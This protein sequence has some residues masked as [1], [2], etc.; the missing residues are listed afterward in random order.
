MRPSKQLILV[1]VL[2]FSL[3][4]TSSTVK[5]GEE[6]EDTFDR[7]AISE[8]IRTTLYSYLADIGQ[9]GLTAE[10]NYLDDS[11][12]FFWVPPGYT[13]ALSYDSV[14]TILLENDGKFDEIRF[15]WETLTVYPLSS[16]IANYTGIV[17]SYMVDT[18]GTVYD[19]RM[20]ES[21]TM[22]LREDG[23]KILSGQS[24]NLPQ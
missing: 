5:N 13:S 15:Q 9:E 10:F 8:D 18:A 3:G 11:P 16:Q 24:R 23:W 12:D 19:T 7:E 2:L 22:I 20:I 4:C 21:G 6:T 1:A 14:K 17:D